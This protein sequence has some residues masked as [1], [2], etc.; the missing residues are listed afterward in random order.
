[1]CRK[2]VEKKKKRGFLFHAPEFIWYYKKYVSYMKMPES[3]V[4]AKKNIPTL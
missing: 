3:N 1:M 4:K 2:S